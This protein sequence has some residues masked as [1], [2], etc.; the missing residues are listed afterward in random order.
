MKKASS[1]TL[2][3]GIKKKVISEIVWIWEEKRK[4]GFTNQS[5]CEKILLN[6]EREAGYLERGQPAEAAAVLVE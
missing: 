5:K 6:R 4:A 3:G 1:Q 2:I